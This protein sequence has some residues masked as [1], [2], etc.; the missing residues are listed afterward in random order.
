MRSNYRNVAGAWPEMR[1]RR[2]P[3]LIILSHNYSV[4]FC[5][6]PEAQAT[7]MIV[8]RH[9]YA[10]GR[11]MA[12]ADGTRMSLIRQRQCNTAVARRTDLRHAHQMHAVQRS[13]SSASNNSVRLNRTEIA[14]SASRGCEPMD[15]S[16]DLFVSDQVHPRLSPDCPIRVIRGQMNVDQS[17][18]GFRN[19]CTR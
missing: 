8:P 15:V 12:F 16:A 10:S 4:T 7:N 6:E 11:R 17:A 9:P 5:F 13:C 14:R 18:T 2:T 19:K 1:I 3:V